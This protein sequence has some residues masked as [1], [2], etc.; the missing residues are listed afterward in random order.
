MGKSRRLDHAMQAREGRGEIAIPA[1]T[2]VLNMKRLPIFF[3]ILGGFTGLLVLS[4]VVATVLGGMMPEQH[5]A[6]VTR[7]YAVPPAEVWADITDFE[8]APGWRKVLASSV[9]LPEPTDDGQE[10]WRETYR[11]GGMALELAVTEME[12]GKLMVRRIVNEDEA[13]F[14]G[15]W[16]YELSPTEGGD[17][18][19]LTI[20]EEGGIN[21]PT[22][23]F[24][25]G[26]LI[27]FDTAIKHYMDALTAKYAH[28]R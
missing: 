25:F 17:G 22:M 16:R 26:K 1:I 8:G 20:T 2:L 12:D 19:S 10:V 14:T 23:R 9:K 15:A 11:E 3:W 28:K 24:V 7:A 6:S 13:G 5:K 4:L 18:T 27:G 21:N